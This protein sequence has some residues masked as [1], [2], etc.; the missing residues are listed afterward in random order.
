MSTN[1]PDLLRDEA[2]RHAA[3][4]TPPPLESLRS[5]AEARGRRTTLAKG[6]AG[7]LVVVGLGAGVVSLLPGLTSGSATSSAASGAAAPSDSVAL[8]GGQMPAASA[9]S[10][11]QAETHAQKAQTPDNPADLA[12]QLRDLTVVERSWARIYLT[13]GWTGLADSRPPVLQFE[14][15]QALRGTKTPRLSARLSGDYYAIGDAEGRSPDS[16]LVA[17]DTKD[18]VVALY[19]LSPSPVRATRIWPVKAS[20]L[21]PTTFRLTD[22]EA[23]LGVKIASATG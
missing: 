1:R 12:K 20:P 19:S 2:L 23:L 7:A 22:L 15:A 21:A 11:T 3:E 4:T 18:E 16:V 5:R 14:G 10:T 17:L 8:S 6:A 9:E 13:S